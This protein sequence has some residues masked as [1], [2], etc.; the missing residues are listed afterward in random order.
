MMKRVFALIAACSFTLMG[1]P[2]TEIFARLDKS[3]AGFR[4]MTADVKQTV[5]T[6]IV[7]DDSAENGT[8][9][10]RRAKPGDVRILLEFTTPNRKTVSVDSDQCR[11]YLPKANTVQVYDLRSRREVVQQ[12]LL[13]GFG[14]TSEEIKAKYEVSLI[15]TEAINGQPTSHLKL[16]PRSKEVLQSLK[17]ADLWLSDSLGV[18]MQQRV[19]TGGSGDYTQLTYSNLQMNP[20]LSD[21]DLKLSVP[22]GVQIQQVGK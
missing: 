10:L 17:Q 18:P 2:L 3:A 5:H 6:A 4:A 21:K 13:L 12:G 16:V 22:K 8:V 9:K 7:N 1:Q 14:A 20:V 15:G 19:V 11:I